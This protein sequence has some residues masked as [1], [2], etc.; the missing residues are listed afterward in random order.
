MALNIFA[1]EEALKSPN[2]NK[3]SYNANRDN[4]GL[5]YAQTLKS[6]GVNGLGVLGV[7]FASYK[8]ID[9]AVNIHQFSSGSGN[10]KRQSDNI[11]LL[12]P[13]FISVSGFVHNTFKIRAIEKQLLIS[14]NVV[15]SNNLVRLKAIKRSTIMMMTI[16]IISKISQEISR[17]YNTKIENR[18]IRQLQN[19]LGF[20]NKNQKLR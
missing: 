10:F 3:L 8:L 18:E 2:Q 20:S 17:T 16:F 5:A 7:G 14:K 11:K 15:A 13:I 19:E 9:S 1:K 4:D 6:K 12:L